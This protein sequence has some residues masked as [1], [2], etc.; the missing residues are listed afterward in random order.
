M[1]EK[2]LIELIRDEYKFAHF[3]YE[4][5]DKETKTSAKDIAYFYYTKGA[6]KA[7]EDLVDR[8]EKLYNEEL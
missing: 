5:A 6:L 2:E 8:V 1:K 7:M 4:K 3:A